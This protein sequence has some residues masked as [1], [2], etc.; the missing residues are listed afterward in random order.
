V[1]APAAFA[2][3]GPNVR[4][5]PRP[6]APAAAITRTSRRTKVPLLTLVSLE[7]IFG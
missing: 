7:A 4:A 3:L 5:A 6:A 1:G 2:A